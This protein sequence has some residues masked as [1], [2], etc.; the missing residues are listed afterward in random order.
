[1]G[2]KV[3]VMDGGDVLTR[4]LETALLSDGHESVSVIVT[5]EN[6]DDGCGAL[7]PHLD[8]VSVVVDLRPVPCTTDGAAE[9]FIAATRRLL[10]CERMTRVGHHVVLSQVDAGTHSRS[11]QAL[12]RRTQEQ[13]ILESHV[14]YSIVRATTLF[15]NLASVSATPSS[16]AAPQ[17][18]P[19]RLQ[20]V[21]ARDVARLIAAVVFD[22][23]LNGV[24]EIGGPESLYLDGV[25]AR[26]RELG[27][28]ARVV[29]LD[30]HACSD[31]S[32]G[33]SLLANEDAEIGE[34]NFDDWLHRA[35][36]AAGTLGLPP[37]QAAT[38]KQFRV[39]DV[40]PGSVLRLDDVAVFSVAGGFCATQ[41]TCTHRAGLLSE[42]TV[43]GTTVI[44]PLHGSR[45]DIWSGAVLHGPATKPL[46]TYR[47]TVDGD[48]GHIEL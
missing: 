25:V 44:C 4:E 9:R 7:R 13:A 20:P 37:D 48:V 46:K 47:V 36:V 3:V 41:A 21:A 30:R 23:P 35:R 38:T 45:F 26:M 2:M 27:R 32:P 14:P 18:V 43:E 5:P 29:H 19:V 22:T 1:M 12:T 16:Q 24:V 39:D 33:E 40:P 8:G 28:D 17:T 11:S 15:E 34:T 6:F 42:G 10:E 31:L